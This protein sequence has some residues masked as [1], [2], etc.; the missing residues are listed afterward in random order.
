MSNEHGG[1]PQTPGAFPSRSATPP[2]A[3]DSTA[4]PA[5]PEPA[6]PVVTSAVSP[7]V[8][9]S[10][11]V[12]EEQSPPPRI[13]A[14]PALRIG[15]SSALGGILLGFLIGLAVGSS[16]SKPE[17]VTT[18]PDSE[19]ELAPVRSGTP[20]A[21]SPGAT[22]AAID[23]SNELAVDL[24]KRDKRIALTGPWTD[25]RIG[26]R[27][28]ARTASTAKLEV[29]LTPG[30]VAY[31]I[32]LIARADEEKLPVGIRVNG[33]DA[34][35]WSV[36]NEWDMYAAVLESGLLRAGANTIEFV[37]PEPSKGEKAE[38]ALVIDSLHLGPLQVSATADLGPANPRGALISGYYGREGEGDDAQSWSAGTKT[39]VG[40]LLKP[41]NS[42]YDLELAGAAFG[43][44]APLGVEAFVNGKS[45]GRAKLD[46]AQAYTFRA[47]PDAF[48][49]GFNLIELVYDKTA[50]PSEFDKK[51]KDM[52]DL[53]IRFNRLTAK[54]AT[55]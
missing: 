41:L 15:V 35:Q 13:A 49:T 22:A 48:V 26:P 10:P 34:G 55:N 19:G 45:I 51:S 46:K 1:F 7:A 36:S 44:L 38:I 47:P 32:A 17:I 54:P 25:V 52:R 29:N 27:S 30:R 33:T 20:A 21:S 50:K 12:A 3:A 4:P 28:G 6:I 2:T 43:P 42:P 40:L 53:A 37:L 24:G 11:A 31:G 23:G 39:R 9:P 14:N 16:R 18:S 8:I 5:A